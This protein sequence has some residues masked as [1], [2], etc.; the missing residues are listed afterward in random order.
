MRAAHALTA[1][2]AL[3]V[4]GL[5]TPIAAAGGAPGG[6]GPTNITVSPFRVHQ[7]STMQ[8]SAA[9]CQQGGLVFSRD[10]TFDSERLSPGSIGFATV[11]I[12]DHARPGRH[13]VHVRCNGSER[14]GSREF[15]VLAARGAQGG[16][17]GS[18]GPSTT[19]TAIGAGLV[20]SAALGAG[21]HLMRR[22]VR[23]TRARV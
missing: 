7:G 1:A 14:E 20:G 4:V 3:A 17:G 8:V 16:L 22:R 18:F 15:E 9:G 23:A 10:N 11:R 2:A 21:I 13:E 6:N 19:E 12:H 5:A